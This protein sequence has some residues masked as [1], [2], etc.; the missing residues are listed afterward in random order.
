M[1]QATEVWNSAYDNDTAPWIIGEPQPAILALER[2][3]RIRGRILDPGTGAGEHT[4]ALTAAGYDILGVDLSP[5]AV[6]YAR[7]NAV[8]KGVP[9]ARFEVTDMVALADSPDNPLGTFDTIVDSALFHVFMD[10]DEARA[11]Y[12]RALH[13]LCEPGGYVHILALS[14]AEPGFGPRIGA[15]LI[16]DSF[17]GPGWELEDLQPDHYYGRVTESNAGQLG[18]LTVDAAGKVKVVA[19]LARIRRTG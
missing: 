16:R 10:D 6:A 14:D 15:D 2:T 19:W 4:I 9:T 5:S 12:V 18:D 7:R 1:T 11:A 8:A 3:G 13:R 17:A